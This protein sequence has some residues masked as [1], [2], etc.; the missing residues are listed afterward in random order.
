MID[1]TK[2]RLIDTVMAVD[3]RFD[4]PSEIREAKKLLNEKYD[5]PLTNDPHVTLLLCPC[6]EENIEI[7]FDE[8]EKLCRRNKKD[9]RNKKK[10]EFKL[11]EVK[12]ED[13][14]KFF[15]MPVISDGL[16][17]FH[18]EVLAIGNKYRAG[19]LRPKDV[20]RFEKGLYTADEQISVEK[21]GH[22]TAGEFFY[23]HV[24]IGKVR[25]AEF[26]ADEILKELQ[27]MLDGLQN[28]LFFVDK[29][30]IVAYLDAQ[31]QD[32]CREI[33]CVDIGV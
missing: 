1:F 13:N 11:G 24:T 25:V 32:D 16:H 30:H 20:E 29:F 14:D 7:C 27:G 8:L 22:R 26:D 12:Y 19:C 17:E 5:N 23:P 21:Y 2:T 15:S 33:R 9:H 3:F 31:R 4:V 28:R 18:N 10:I 6:P